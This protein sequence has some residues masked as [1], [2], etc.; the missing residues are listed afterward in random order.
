MPKAGSTAL[1]AA[2]ANARGRL[3]RQ[4]VLYPRGPFISRT[5]NFLIAGLEDRKR[6]LPRSRGSCPEGTEGACRCVEGSAE[7]VCHAHALSTTSWTPSPASG[8]G[9]KTPYA[10]APLSGG[11]IEGWRRRENREGVSIPSD[12]D[13]QVGAV[14]PGPRSWQGTAPDEDD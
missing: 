4:G 11:G 1:Q 2:L 7:A 14:S 13:Y 12:L 5:H 10:I 8:R 9:R 6:E 3:D